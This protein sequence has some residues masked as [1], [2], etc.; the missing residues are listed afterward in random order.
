MANLITDP[1]TEPLL[2]DLDYDNLSAMEQAKV[3][4]LVTAGSQLIEKYCNRVFT[5][6]DYTDELVNG[7]G[8]N[9]VF[10][11]N[12]PINSLT[13]VKVVLVDEE[14]TFLSSKLKFSPDTGRISLDLTQVNYQDFLY[15]FPRGYQNVKVTYNGGFSEI[16]EPIKLVLADFVVNAYYALGDEGDIIS[17]KLGQYFYKSDN[18]NKEKSA[19]NISKYDTYLQFYRIRKA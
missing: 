15:Y 4:A 6:A 5:A 9:L 3:N 8:H 13:S 1:S 19:V 16:P 17:E 2:A 14:L 10:A 11:L 18:T 12:P 7:T